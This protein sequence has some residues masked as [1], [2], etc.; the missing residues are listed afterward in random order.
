M[1]YRDEILQAIHDGEYFDNVPGTL[2]AE[3]L[4]L[5]TE[6]VREIT[7][8]ADANEAEVSAT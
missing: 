5:A 1:G 2:A 6:L 4:R 7:E 3:E 8:G